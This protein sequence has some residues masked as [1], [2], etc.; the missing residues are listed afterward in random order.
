MEDLGVRVSAYLDS[1]PKGKV[2][3]WRQAPQL[4]PHSPTL[5]RAQGLVRRGGVTKHSGEPVFQSGE[6]PWFEHDLSPTGSWVE[7]LLGPL[8]VVLTLSES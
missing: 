5:N 8:L 3:W 2:K 4:L 1:P 7:I 6:K